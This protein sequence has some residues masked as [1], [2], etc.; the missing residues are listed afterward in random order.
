MTNEQNFL[1][2]MK[3]VITL[4]ND[5]EKVERDIRTDNNLSEEYKQNLIAD[6][7]EEY[8]FYVRHVAMK[9][10]SIIK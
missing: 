1:Q 5:W 2:S 3:R 10:L 4:M 7:A 8:A 6:K 9:A